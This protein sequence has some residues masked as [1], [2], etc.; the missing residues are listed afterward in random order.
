MRAAKAVC[1][2]LNRSAFS[3]IEKRTKEVFENRTFSS[4]RLECAGIVRG[5]LTQ[6][7]KK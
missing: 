1:K 6:M 3:G 5:T 4:L 7:F 2:S